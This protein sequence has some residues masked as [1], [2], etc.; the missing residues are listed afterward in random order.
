[1]TSVF[2]S[3]IFL[4]DYQD[5]YL[6]TWIQS[7]LPTIFYIDSALHDMIEEKLVGHSHIKCKILPN[8]EDMSW[9]DQTI[10]QLPF[11]RN[12]EKDNL[13]FIWG[14]HLKVFCMHQALQISEKDLFI[15]MD[16]NCADLFLEKKTW[17]HLYDTHSK[18]H[19]YTPKSN[20]MFIP[21]CWIKIS[22]SITADFANSVCWRFCGNYFLGDRSAIEN[23]YKQYENHFNKFLHFTENV[24]TWSMNFWA[25][26][27]VFTDFEPEW[28]S[29]DHSDSLTKTPKVFSYQK[30]SEMPE[31]KI[32]EYHYPN[33]SP[34]RPMHSSF[35]RYNNMDLI[36]TRFVNYW[37]YNGGNYYYPEDE[38]VL[39]SL[40]VVSRLVNIENIPTPRTYDIMREESDFAKNNNVFS[41]GIE[42]IRLYVSQESGNLSFI[43]STLS[44]SY[45]DR[46]RMVR[47]AYDI[48]TMTC[49]NFQVIKPPYDS[50]CEK[51]WCPI[52][53]NDGTDGFIY[54]WYPFE[55]GKIYP[56]KESHPFNIGKTE[57]CLRKE[58]DERL[59]D[60]KGST[61]FTQYGDD[62]L[63]GIIHFSEE[64]SP[65]QY[66][67][68]VIVLDK[69]D[70]NIVKMSRPFC[71][72]KACV[73]FCIGFR[74]LNDCFGFWISQMDRDPQYLEVP[75]K[76]FW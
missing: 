27:E 60:M 7:K 29:A 35:V 16:F 12:D 34:Y 11:V 3:C 54:R 58:P 70:Y 15:F 25:W 30:I 51:N 53:L 41:E 45:C 26:L 2:V 46:I 40:N 8:F 57:I 52:P 67:H 69:H 23:F 76:Y 42:D 44:Y 14:T 74:V 10:T 28:Y 5:S 55:I 24:L 47:G 48:H 17:E 20:T 1:M 21:G 59:K 6:D 61:A 63:I 73:E 50:W 13:D 49:K 66:F 9:Y 64:R 75:E 56:E 68:H 72:Q 38:Y 43:G 65:R 33:L 19:L 37:I 62:A 71:F 4:D 39:R 32:V 36:N 22:T 31:C 18:R